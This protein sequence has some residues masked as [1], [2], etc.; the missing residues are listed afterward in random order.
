MTTSD[1]LEY[2]VPTSLIVGFLLF[3][4]LGQVSREKAHALVHTGAKLLDVRTAAEF[5]AGHLSGALNLP[6]SELSARLSSL[7]ARDYPI[8]LYCASGTRS[9][10]AR[11]ILKGQGFTQVY[12]LGAMGRW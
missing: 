2:A 10:V 8:V 12:N 11:S 7:G 5:E 4:R 9:A 6:L 3:K 1:L